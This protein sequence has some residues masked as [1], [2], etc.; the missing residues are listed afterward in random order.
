MQIL[1]FRQQKTTNHLYLKSLI[2]QL[3]LKTE[4]VTCVNYCPIGTTDSLFFNPVNVSFLNEFEMFKG[5]INFL[6]GYFYHTLK[7]LNSQYH[8]VFFL[9]TA[10][11]IAGIGFMLVGFAVIAQGLLGTYPTIGQMMDG[12]RTSFTILIFTQTFLVSYS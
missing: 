5:R 4:F 11:L 6:N 7:I 2:N 12:I 3:V 10:S 8:I 1:S 9:G